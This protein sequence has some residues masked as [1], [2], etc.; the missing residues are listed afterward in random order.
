LGIAA[1]CRGNDR[2][3]L[4]GSIRCDCRGFGIATTGEVVDHLGDMRTEIAAACLFEQGGNA[5]GEGADRAAEQ[6][7]PT[8]RGPAPISSP[9]IAR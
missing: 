3:G 4:G 6:H 1:A 5:G 7:T 8:K 2:C 9:V